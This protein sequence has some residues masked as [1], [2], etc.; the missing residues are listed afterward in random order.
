MPQIKGI[1]VEGETMLLAE[2]MVGSF[3]DKLVSGKCTMSKSAFTL[4]SPIIVHEDSPES[5]K[6][7]QGR[8]HNGFGTC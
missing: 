4:V 5:S 7:D 1:E 8:L 2:T 6:L 3:M